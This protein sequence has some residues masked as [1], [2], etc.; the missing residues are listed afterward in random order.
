METV[1]RASLSALQGVQA[2]EPAPAFLRLMPLPPRPAPSEGIPSDAPRIVMTDFRRADDSV[3]SQKERDII[4]AARR[5]LEQHDKRP[6]DAYYR[7]KHAPEGFEVGVSY[8]VDVSY[9][10]GYN[11]N[12][13][14]FIS[15]M[16]SVLLRED[17]SVIRVLS[18]A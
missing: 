1:R 4:V 11:G 17:G 12:Q 18:G 6:N 3:F 15:V 14:V 8:E 16:I 7:V 5:H 10:T 13:P 9:V 2:V